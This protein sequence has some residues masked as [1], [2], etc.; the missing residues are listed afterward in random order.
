MDVR[1]GGIRWSEGW[2]TLSLS[3][4]FKYS[5]Q[6]LRAFLRVKCFTGW[7]TSEIAHFL[8]HK[9]IESSEVLPIKGDDKGFII[10]P[11]LQVSDVIH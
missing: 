11:R 1:G 7:S 10:F 4:P 6:T 2:N 3:F 5:K 9:S 8:S